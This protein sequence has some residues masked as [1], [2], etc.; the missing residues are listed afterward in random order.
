[1]SEANHYLNIQPATLFYSVPQITNRVNYA[2]DTERGL[3]GTQTNKKWFKPSSS[4]QFSKEAK[5]RIIT[6][7][8]HWLSLPCLETGQTEDSRCREQSLCP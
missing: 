8:I 5:T 2:E 3:G 4:L 1:L 6:N 7:Y